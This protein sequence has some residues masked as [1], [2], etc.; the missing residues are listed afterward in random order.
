MGEVCR[1]AALKGELEEGSLDLP[2]RGFVEFDYRTVD[3]WSRK[4]RVVGKV[5]VLDKGE[6]LRFVV[7]NFKP[8][9][10]S[11]ALRRPTPRKSTAETTRN[12]SRIGAERG[13]RFG[14]MS[15]S[16]T[17][18]PFRPRSPIRPDVSGVLAL[19][20]PRK[21]CRLPVPH[22]PGSSRQRRVPHFL[23]PGDQAYRRS[24]CTPDCIAGW[25]AAR[26]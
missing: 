22:R 21:E 19:G 24:H 6:N 11:K 5:E 23:L 25:P 9:L 13:T 8:G 3:S 17:G 2:V 4:R 10:H 12:K 20:E 18:N 15:R 16:G 26:R 7:T 14:R 1:G